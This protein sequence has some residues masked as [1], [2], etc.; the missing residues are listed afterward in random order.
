[1]TNRPPYPLAPWD[2]IGNGPHLPPE[3]TR[4]HE[5]RCLP[6]DIGEEQLG[7]PVFGHEWTALAVFMAM[8]GDVWKQPISQVLNRFG[9]PRS[10]RHRPNFGLVAIMRILSLIEERSACL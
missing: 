10:D 5:F 9:F 2:L 8:Y 6:I 4:R 1:L 3:E 7:C